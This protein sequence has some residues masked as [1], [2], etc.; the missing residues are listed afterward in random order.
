MGDRMK[1]GMFIKMCARR[2]IDKSHT[3]N[4]SGGGKRQNL[5]LC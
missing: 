3:I 2:I 1:N 5:R 4:S